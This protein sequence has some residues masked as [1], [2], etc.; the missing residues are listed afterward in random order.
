[1]FTCISNIP[2]DRGT[3]T[4]VE[5]DRCRDTEVEQEEPQQKQGPLQQQEQLYKNNLLQEEAVVVV[6]FQDI[7]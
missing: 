2:S 3:S 7:H 5:F 4:S 1:M 6:A